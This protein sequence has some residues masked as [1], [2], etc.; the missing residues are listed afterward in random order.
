MNRRQVLVNA[1]TSAAQVIVIS[2]ILFILYRF[3]LRTIGVDHLGIWS[4]VLA[5]TSVTQ[6]AHLGLSGSVIKFVAKYVARDEKEHVLGI[7]QTAVISLGVVVGIVILAGYPVIKWVLGLVVPSESLFIAVEILPYALLSLWLMII[8]SIFQSGLDGYQRFDIRNLLLIGGA[9]IHLILCFILTPRHGLVGL[10]YAKVAQNILTLLFSWIMLKKYI[11]RLPFIPHKWN[12]NLFKE[13][14]GYGISFQM[15]SFAQLF[16]DPVT[17]ALLSRFGGLSMVGYYEMA[18]KM[19]LQ[20][21]ALIVSSTQ[22]LVPVFAEMNGKSSEKIQS[23]YSSSYQLLFYLALPLHSLLIMNM[24]II[25]ELW[26]GH[27]ENIF[28]TFGIWLAIG[29]L[30]KALSIPAQVSYLGTGELRWVVISHIS[31]AFLNACLGLLLGTFYDGM[32]VVIAWVF[33]L[34][35]GSSIIY[36]SYHL[37][38]KIS[39]YELLPFASRKLV[40]VCLIAIPLSLFIQR[41][42]DYVFDSVVLKILLII[43]SV[44]II[45]LLFWLH[46]MRK[47]LIRWMT[48]ELWQKKK[49]VIDKR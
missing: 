31:I 20:F 12:K 5:T 1:I 6:I 4:L 7:I 36:V 9:F 48:D 25:S 10:A 29:W 13:I 28:V 23:V 22:V 42:F 24:P 43:F 15:I 17:K 32:G 38:H 34:F 30:L 35:L 16:Y 21:R 3:L 33:S 41:E 39:M 49:A 26:I 45:F 14:I 46:P 44:T 27:Y 8:T 2:A 11:P 37:K 18:S 47:N 40:V 19:I